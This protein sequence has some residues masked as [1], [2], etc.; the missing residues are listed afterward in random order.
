M[1]TP[2]FIGDTQSPDCNMDNAT[3]AS[4]GSPLVLK[5]EKPK[6]NTTDII[7]KNKRYMKPL[8]DFPILLF[9]ISYKLFNIANKSSI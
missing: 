5:R 9:I 6:N 1:S 4:R 3:T 7:P 8:C 2:L